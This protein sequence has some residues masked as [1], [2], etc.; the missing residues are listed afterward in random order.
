MAIPRIRDLSDIFDN[1]KVIILTV[2]RRT[3]NVI[4]E[5]LTDGTTDLSINSLKV[6]T[7]TGADSLG[8][9]FTV[10]A[11]ETI[12]I[13]RVFRISEDDGKGYL[14]D[15]SSVEGL[16]NVTGISGADVNQGRTIIGFTQ[17]FSGFLD[18]IPGATY[19]L[20]P[21]GKIV[22]PEP[23]G[24]L[25]EI[26]VAN[27]DGVLIITNK[28]LEVQG[29]FIDIQVFESDSFWSVPDLMTE[30]GYIDVIVVGGGSG[31]IIGTGTVDDGFD[32]MFGIEFSATGGSGMTMTSNTFSSGLRRAGE[33]IGGDINIMG[34]TSYVAGNVTHSGASSLFIAGESGGS[35]FS[36]G[37]QIG[38]LFGNL[39]NNIT[40]T[41]LYPKSYGLGGL[42][43]SFDSVDLLVSG[44][45]GG[46]T[47]KKRIIKARFNNL[48]VTF[49]IGGTDLNQSIYLGDNSTFTY[50][51]DEQH[52]E[53]MDLTSNIT[54]GTIFGVSDGTMSLFGNDGASN[55]I[56]NANFTVV[57]ADISGIVSAIQ[58]V[59]PVTISVSNDGNRIIFKRAADLINFNVTIGPGSSRFPLVNTNI[60]DGNDG[61]V[62][63]KSYK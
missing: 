62:I 61:V 33:G 35:I 11:G 46:G 18:L 41:N 7:I 27:S 4:V 31:A 56:L 36:N 23:E 43:I 54:T 6:N 49:G 17:S 26:G 44:G 21:D 40:N 50:S 29:E 19:Y 55:V 51:E 12:P 38:S 14:T 24:K 45:K 60:T 30:K 25:Y 9:V 22:T 39:N 1:G 58:A 57:S 42:V 15:N 32:S 34:G 20:L 63:V 5:W 37:T 13:N 52:I 10:E 16:T 28:S 47:A 3:L 8:G 2:F 53:S 59:I 48:F